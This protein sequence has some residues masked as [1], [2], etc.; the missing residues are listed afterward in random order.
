MKT[1]VSLGLLLATSLFVAPAHAVGNAANGKA[2]SAACAACHGPD[3]NS[4]LPL[5]PKLA[6]QHADYLQQA[7]K[8]Y[9]SGARKNEIM[10]G[11]AA[12]LSAQDIEDL[13]AF[14]ASQPGLVV[15]R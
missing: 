2:K 14:Y 8:G 4:P 9:K 12:P 6:G 15:K 13:A 3:G 1:S 10:K 11:M 5:Y 7:L